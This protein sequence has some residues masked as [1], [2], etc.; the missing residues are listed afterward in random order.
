MK[1]NPTNP[2]YPAT[3]PNPLS[4]EEKQQ[5][6]RFSS[7]F[8]QKVDQSHGTSP[9]PEKS[10]SPALQP[11]MRIMHCPDFQ[12]KTVTDLLDRL[13]K[14]Q[15]MLSDHTATLRDIAPVVDDMKKFS[16]EGQIM[17]TAIDH[18]NPIQPLLQE[19]VLVISKEI[20]RFNHGAYIDD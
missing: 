14:Y 13:E 17:L 9:I 1:I 11:S 18:N 10:V 4:A 12:E 2:L 6:E 3:K 7:I 16:D 19:T 8:E 15:Q 20:E 5:G